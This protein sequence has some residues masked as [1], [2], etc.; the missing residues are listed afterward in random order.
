LRASLL[1]EHSALPAAELTCDLGLAAG[2][3]PAALADVPREVLQ[4]AERER[5]RGGSSRLS[6]EIVKRRSH[7]QR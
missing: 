1:S 6:P 3:G 4:K 7:P 5:L 2:G